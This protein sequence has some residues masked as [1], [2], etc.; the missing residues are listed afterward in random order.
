MC[1][2]LGW[3]STRRRRLWGGIP[4]GGSLKGAP[5]AAHKAEC[6][7]T[8]RAA[9][10]PKTPSSLLVRIIWQN[11]GSCWKSAYRKRNSSNHLGASS[12]PRAS[13]TLTLSRRRTRLRRR[14][15]A[16][17]ASEMGTCCTTATPSAKP[18]H[19][20]T[21]STDRYADTAC[22]LFEQMR[23]LESMEDKLG[24]QVQQLS[25]ACWVLAFFGANRPTLCRILW[26]AARQ[27]AFAW[28]LSLALWRR[29]WTTYEMRWDYR[30]Q[31]GLSDEE[32]RRRR[33]SQSL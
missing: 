27:G 31:T 4:D 16:M 15:S 5:D 30:G 24:D 2:S 28:T 22:G 10:T 23:E 14:T 9:I 11:I 8:S 13:G 1:I 12:F 7:A 17:N 20:I 6:R 19:L 18:P 25:V 21:R 32:N 33:G 29:I 3:L 26:P